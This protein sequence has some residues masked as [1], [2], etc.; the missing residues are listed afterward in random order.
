MEG[1]HIVGAQDRKQER[2]LIA[3]VGENRGDEDDGHDA[4]D[5]PRRPPVPNVP[6]VRSASIAS[7]AGSVMVCVHES[8]VFI[9]ASAR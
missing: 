1:E 3:R 2:H 7:V 9:P 4:D 6:S 5:D 8:R